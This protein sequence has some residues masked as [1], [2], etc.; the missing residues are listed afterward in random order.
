MIGGNALELIVRAPRTSRMVPSAARTVSKVKG[1]HDLRVASTFHELFESA[2]HLI[3]QDPHP[4][5]QARRAEPQ[6]DHA[7]PS[8]AHSSSGASWMRCE[9]PRWSSASGGSP[10]TSA[11]DTKSCAKMA[12]EDCFK[13]SRVRH[14]C[15]SKELS[16]KN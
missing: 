9:S 4:Y 15:L 2:A 1:S 13:L 7:S 5:T 11:R 16:M 3:S 14:E 6:R 12:T 8:C 10:S